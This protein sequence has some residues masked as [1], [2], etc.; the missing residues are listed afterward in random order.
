MDLFVQL[1]G[2]SGLSEGKVITAGAGIFIVGATTEVTATD[3]TVN[4]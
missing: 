2:D 4:R 3:G 1:T